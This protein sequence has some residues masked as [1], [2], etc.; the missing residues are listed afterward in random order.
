MRRS[1]WFALACILISSSAQAAP[2]THVI[3][4]GKWQA[5]EWLA[6]S[7]GERPVTIKV[8]PL[9]VDGKFREHTVGQPHDITERLFVVQE[10]LRL[11]DALPGDAPSPQLWRWERA[12]WLVVDRS[13]GRVLPVA[14]P[15]FDPFYSSVTWYRDYVAYC[16]VSD[17][18]KRLSLTVVQ[19]GRKKPLLHKPLE[20]AEL[21]DLPGSACPAPAWFRNPVRVEFQLRGGQKL[22][23]SP[24]YRALDTVTAD[25]AEDS[26]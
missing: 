16:G 14:L 13:S 5:V 21:G 12:G 23:F 4:F 11:N 17:N 18:G 19:L 10:A 15:E 1:V 20:A 8:R 24:R 25:E 7:G 22:T 6:G 3:S 9:Y 26:D 2:K